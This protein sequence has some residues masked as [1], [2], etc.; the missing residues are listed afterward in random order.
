MFSPEHRLIHSDRF[1]YCAHPHGVRLA[2]GEI[3]VV[4]NRVPRREVILHPPQDPAFQNVLT[5]SGDGGRTWSAP[6]VV[7]D[8]GW[9]GVECAG[10]TVLR[11]GRV[12]LNQWRFRWY[13]LPLAC[14]KAATE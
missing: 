2:S 11:S 12:L 3:V 5:R 10:L 6:S 1:S 7:P 4:F 14:K 8:Y 13:P 9:T